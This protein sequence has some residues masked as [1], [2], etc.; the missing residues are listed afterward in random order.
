MTSSLDGC[1]AHAGREGC[2]LECHL[3]RRGA[4][5]SI[6]A[7]ERSFDGEH[8]LARRRSGGGHGQILLVGR[9]V[10]AETVLLAEANKGSADL[11]RLAERKVLAHE[12]VGDIR[13]EREALGGQS[14]A[15]RSTLNLAVAIMPVKAGSNTSRTASCCTSA[16]RSPTS[17]PA[18]STCARGLHVAGP[19][20]CPRRQ[21]RRAADGRDRRTCA[22][23]CS[24]RSWPRCRSSTCVTTMQ[25]TDA[26]AHRHRVGGVGQPAR[27]SRRLRVHEVVL[28]LRQ[29]R[30]DATTPPC[31]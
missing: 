30:R 9:L 11:V 5:C 25:D 19:A 1:R 17:S 13:R 26:P 31:S 15:I 24:G 20:R 2:Q 12:P 7:R 29:R 3:L 6:P 10:E 16:T 18:P 21:C 8:T 27:R 23:T 22:P 4:A 14:S 28:A